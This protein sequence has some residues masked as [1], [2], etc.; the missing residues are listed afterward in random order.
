MYTGLH[1]MTNMRIKFSHWNRNKGKTIKTKTIITQFSDNV[2]LLSMSSI[3]IF[4]SFKLKYAQ[5][6]NYNSQTFNNLEIRCTWQLVFNFAWYMY[7]VARQHKTCFMLHVT[8]H[9]IETAGFTLSDILSNI[10]HHL[11]GTTVMYF[12]STDNMEI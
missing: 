12:L 3:F 4:Q 6:Q 11:P 2:N 1:F 10:K 7:D 8:F 9:N 5:Y